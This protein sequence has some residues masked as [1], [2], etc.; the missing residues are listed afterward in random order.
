M[1]LGKDGRS[2]RSGGPR[3][4]AR[5]RIRL[6]EAWEIPNVLNVDNRAWPYLI[7]AVLLLVLIYAYR[8]VQP[9]GPVA[10]WTAVQAI[11]I[12]ATGL[13]AVWNLALQRFSQRARLTVRTLESEYVAQALTDFG[14]VIQSANNSLDQARLNFNALVIANPWDPTVSRIVGTF[15]YV[16]SLYARGLLDSQILF[17]KDALTIVQGAYVVHDRMQ[18]LVNIGAVNKNVFAM[19]RAAKM[20][21]DR[22]P[23]VYV[24]FPML[25]N[26]SV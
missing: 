14:Q 20:I 9:A 25:Q 11:A 21:L 12:A 5:G 4:R 13:F 15:C 8:T 16:G 1:V 7:A 19:V 24:A 23:G 26:Y 3:T 22:T 2:F 18:T 17:S 6:G 10:A